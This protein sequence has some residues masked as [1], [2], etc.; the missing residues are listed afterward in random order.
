[1]IGG[2]NMKTVTLTTFSNSIEAHMLQDLLKN[3]GIHSML[4]G[5]TTNQVLSPMMNIG[6]QVLVFE[7]DLEAAKFILKEAFPNQ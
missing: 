6:V 4:Q 5:E 2:K 3:E 7:A 1:M